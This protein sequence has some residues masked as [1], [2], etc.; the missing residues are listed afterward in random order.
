MAFKCGKCKGSHEF[1]KEGRACYEGVDLYRCDWLIEIATED[2]P[3]IVD[4]GAWAIGTDRGFTCEAGHSHV[5][6]EIRS[7]E[8]WDYADGPHEAKNMAKYGIFPMTMD[9]TGPAEV[10]R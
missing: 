1:A 4:C 3:A 2:G 9:G 10:A 8:G 7:R 5:N 6:C